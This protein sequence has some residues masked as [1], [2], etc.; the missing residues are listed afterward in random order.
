MTDWIL[1]RFELEDIKFFLEWRKNVARR[2]K[3]P[4]YIKWEYL[5]GPWGKAETWIADDNGKIVG[6]YSTQRYE[7]FYFGEKMMAS[8]SFDTGVHPKYFHPKKNIFQ[9]LGKKFF[10]EEAKQEINFSTGFPNEYFLFGGIRFGWKIVCPVPLLEN[11][12]VA[13]LNIKSNS[14]YEVVEI[15]EFDNDFKGFSENYK[16]EIPILL[17]RTQRYLNW[18]FVEKPS[19]KESKNHY[20][21]FKYKILDKTG[22]LVSYFVTKYYPS[23]KGKKLQLMDFLIPKEEEVYQAILA[24]LIKE[25][26]SENVNIISLFIN[27][28]NPFKSYLQKYGFNLIESKRRFIVRNNTNVLKDKNLLDEQ[29]HFITMGDHDVY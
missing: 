15:H 20:N 8:Y 10:E 13:E 23:E 1:R 24:F 17:N 27:R 9:A 21:Y 4:E 16:D 29:N 18:R 28:F 12:T 11:Y 7:A 22:E 19:L 3:T 6:Q 25:A 14:R 2:D 26:K 5:N